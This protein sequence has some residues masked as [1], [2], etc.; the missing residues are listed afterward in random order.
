[1]VVPQGRPRCTHRE[2]EAAAAAEEGGAARE[3]SAAGLSESRRGSVACA[4]SHPPGIWE[5][6]FVPWG[7]RARTHT[8][9]SSARSDVFR[10]PSLTPRSLDPVGARAAPPRGVPWARCVCVWGGVD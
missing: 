4:L 9:L 2:E 7:P 8:Q 5:G 1:M 6:G 10:S 3:V